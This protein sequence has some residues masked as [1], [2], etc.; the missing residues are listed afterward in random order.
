ML[1]L[2]LAPS[3]W[4][5]YHSSLLHFHNHC[6]Q[7]SLDFPPHEDTAVA[8]IANFIK[9]AMRA[10]QRPSLTINGLLA[11]INSL[12]EPLGLHP[13]RDPLIKRLHRALVRDRTKRPI[14]HGS[15]FD[16]TC[17]TSLF[18]KWGRNTSITKTRAK[19]IAMLCT[20]GA[21]RVSAATLP[22]F[23]DVT[24]DRR[25]GKKVL[26]V[27]VVGY[28]ND[29]LGEG[30]AVHLY[31]CSDKRLCPVVTWKRWRLLTTALRR[32]IREPRIVFELTSPFKQLSPDRCA[33][34]LKGVA[35]AAKLDT[36][37]FTARTFRKSGIMAGINAGVEPDAI[38]RLGGW[39]D[40]DTF[41]RHYVVR[42]I[43]SSFTDILFDAA[44]PSDDDTDSDT[45]RSEEPY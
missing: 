25:D 9:A 8:T 43:P 16:I 7:D 19:L 37:V 28:K 3:T 1:D 34:I 41:W 32:K 4:R 13:T 24:V 44:N 29:F 26:V 36:S 20:L 33:S 31:A 15:T 11:A 40:P 2:A 39:R 5:Q 18:K 14:C 42:E 22:H 27:P 45:D 10:T 12:F 35:R 6:W 30:N 23:D 21:L 38:F 17:L